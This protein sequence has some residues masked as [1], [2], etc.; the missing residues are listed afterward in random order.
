MSETAIVVQGILKD[1]GTLE[2]DERPMLSPGR[3]Q[4]MIL[5]IPVSTEGQVRRSLVDVLNEIHA[6]QRARGY[7]GRTIE[8]MEADEDERRKSDEDYEKRWRTIS[9]PTSSVS[10]SAEMTK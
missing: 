6:G 3:V 7:L 4:V 5:P 8:E 1:N 2:L 10:P 9:S